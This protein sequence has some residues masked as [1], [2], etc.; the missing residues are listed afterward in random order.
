MCP[1]RFSLLC[2]R[3]ESC[4]TVVGGRA[5]GTSLCLGARGFSLVQ[6]PVLLMIAPWND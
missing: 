2:S 1:I 3:V 6:G 4:N 5:L